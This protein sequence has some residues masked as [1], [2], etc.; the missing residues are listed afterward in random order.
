MA[1]LARTFY[2]TQHD[3][4]DYLFL[5]QS[6]LDAKQNLLL[7]ET[8]AIETSSATKTNQAFN[9]LVGF[10]PKNSDDYRAALVGR[11]H[12]KSRRHELLVK[13]FGETCQAKGISAS[14]PPTR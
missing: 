2:E 9:P 8:G 6:A 7:T 5:Y 1:A 4:D 10:K 3:L 14:T 12:I 13:N 11:T